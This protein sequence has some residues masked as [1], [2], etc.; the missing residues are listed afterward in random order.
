MI[1][2]NFSFFHNTFITLVVMLI[3]FTFV[4]NVHADDASNQI[5]I[6]KGTAKNLYGTFKGK[7]GSPSGIKQNAVAPLM[8]SKTQMSTLN[9]KKQFTAQIEC[10]SAEDFL[11]ILFQPTD[12][13]DFHAVI[14]QDTNLSGKLNYQIITPLISGA[15]SQGFVSCDAGTWNNCKFYQWAV[16]QSGELNYRQVQSD[17]LLGTCIC[18]NSSCNANFMN[19]FGQIASLFGS[20]VASFIAANIHFAV[21]DIKINFPLIKYFGQNSKSCKVIANKPYTGTTYGDLTKYYKNSSA[22]EKNAVPQ[23]V[24]GE[25]QNSKSPYYSVINNS[26]LDNQTS[27]YKQCV[28]RKIPT[29]DNATWVTEGGMPAGN[30]C[31]A[32]EPLGGGLYKCTVQ[33]INGGAGICGNNCCVTFKLYVDGKWDFKGYVYDDKRVRIII[34]GTTYVD[35]GSCSPTGGWDPWSGS[36]GG[37]AHGEVYASLCNAGEC[38]SGYDSN[39]GKNM[40]AV[41]G[42]FHIYLYRQPG[43][44]LIGE[45]T[46]SS[47]DISSCKL[48]DEQVCDVNG[49]NCVYTIK[50]FHNTGVTLTGSCQGLTDQ[51]TGENFIVCSNGNRIWYQ[52]EG[53]SS[54]A[55]TLES[56]TEEW[57]YI[58]RTYQCEQKT[59]QVTGLNREKQVVESETY[60]GN[61][62]TYFDSGTGAGNI[63][64]YSGSYNIIWKSDYSRYDNCTFSC[65]VKKTTKRTY[66]VVGGEEVIGSSTLKPNN[67]T[68]HYRVIACVKENNQWQCPVPDNYTMEQNCMCTDKGTQSIAVMKALVQAARDLTCSKE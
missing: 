21:S 20:G 46:C 6:S 37:V 67:S 66:A 32:I 1:K 68:S 57:W 31:Q 28:I 19:M 25:S 48:K 55:E 27:E 7:Y 12:T 59:I 14:S 43:I 2:V 45:D 9:G 36:F 34:A 54:R 42:V 35:T 61:N 38:N 64:P 22:M 18:V 3:I 52:P 30:I 63:N 16:N 4:F 33:P 50:D 26:Y 17:A 15:C 29:L 62:A 60:N 5:N 49:N 47:L 10:P 40:P 58:K 65:V 11:E 44:K 56:G 24:T 8:S 23:A 53:N 51:E 13:G 39:L 41:A